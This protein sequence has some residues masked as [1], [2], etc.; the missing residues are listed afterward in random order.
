LR[1]NVFNAIYGL[2]VIIIIE[3]KLWRWKT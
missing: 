1:Q 2:F 3:H